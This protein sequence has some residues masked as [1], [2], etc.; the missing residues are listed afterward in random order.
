VPVI[1]ALALIRRL[2]DGWKPE[3]GAYP[4]SGFLNLNELERLLD[5]LGI[6]HSATAE[7]ADL[8]LAA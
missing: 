7:A 4:C 2:R 5:E 3:P 6:G 8:L 1:P